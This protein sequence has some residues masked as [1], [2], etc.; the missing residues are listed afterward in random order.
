[1][2]VYIVGVG[3]CWSLLLF[4]VRSQRFVLIFQPI[5]V[6]VAFRRQENSFQYIYT[7][8]SSTDFFVPWWALYFCYFSWFSFLQSSCSCF[9]IDTSISTFR[10][11]NISIILFYNLFGLPL[12]LHEHFD[13]LIISAGPELRVSRS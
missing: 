2:C 13:I 9:L 7:F 12:F 11:F 3:R 1:M 4:F 10:Y 6:M 5:L 8:F